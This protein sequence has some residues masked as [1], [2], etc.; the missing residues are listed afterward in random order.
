MQQVKVA[1]SA[2]LYQ[3]FSYLWPAHLGEPRLGL[4]VRVPFGHGHRFGVLID[5]HDQSSFPD[6]KSVS[7]RYE[8][9]AVYQAARRQWLQRSMA[10]Y[11]AA[12]GMMWSLAMSFL[13]CEEKQK[14]SATDSLHSYDTELAHALKRPLLLASLCKKLGHEH[15]P[16]WRIAKAI[17][18]GHLKVQSLEL[19]QA[20]PQFIAPKTIRLTEQQGHAIEQLKKLQGFQTALLFGCTGS[21]KTEV[22]MQLAKQY[23]QAG[24][25]VLILAPEIGLTPMWLARLQQSFASIRVWHSALSE[26]QRLEVL[27]SM[28]QLDVLLGTRS[29]LFLPL[30]RLRLIIIDEEHDESFKQQDGVHYSARDMAVLLA[31]QLNIPLVLGSATPSQET[32]RQV[33][34]GHYQC[35]ELSHRIQKHRVEKPELIDMRCIHQPLSAQLIQALKDNHQEGGQALLYLNRRAYSPALSCMACGHIPRCPACSLNLSLHRQAKQLRCHACGYRM[36][37]PKHCHACDEEALAPLGEGTERIDELLA[38]SLPELR[39]ARLDRDAI[40]NKDE[41]QQRLD[42]FARGRIDVLIGTQMI[43]K[44]HDFP[45]VRLVAVINADLGL[46]M[47][48]F[49]AG[50]RWWQQMTQVLGRTGRGKHAGRVLIQSRNPEADWLQQLD[51]QKAKTILMQE[52]QIRQQWHYPP[53]ARWV[54]IVCSSG[55]LQYAEQE[56]RTIY[57]QIKQQYP[58]LDVVEP[59]PCPLE[60]LGN[61]FRIELLVKD[62]SRQHLP[63]CLQPIV[64]Q[65]AMRGVRRSIDVD[66]HDLM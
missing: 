41:L 27:Q 18:A 60:R 35:V 44:G 17:Q 39:S 11:L 19:Q 53:F 1:V 62:Q 14:L 46:N 48:D 50:E 37:A 8:H 38:E 47:P 66:P 36:S 20:K 57:Q 3:T 43:I 64:Q 49:R 58:E 28:Q 13:Q 59:M 32:W 42:D 22:Y 10:Y 9:T 45:N 12:P 33:Q 51:E 25:Q 30:P 23:T 61:R 34:S 5:V 21:G 26:Q 24:G 6:L 65:P 52:Q 40:Q 16:R 7:D 15:A 4:R 55:R 2:P 54:R 56:A 29:A 31:Q 63:W